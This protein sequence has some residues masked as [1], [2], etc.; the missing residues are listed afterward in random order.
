MMEAANAI[1]KQGASVE[2]GRRLKTLEDLRTHLR[3]AGLPKPLLSGMETALNHAATFLGVPPEQLPIDSVADVVDSPSDFKAHLRDRKYKR[4]TARSYC[5]SLRIAVNKARA[6]GWSPSRPEVPEWEPIRKAVAQRGCGK[7]VGYA[8]REGI[9]PSEFT[10]EHLETWAKKR[11][12]SAKSYSATVKMKE[13]FRRQIVRAG[14]QASLP[15]LTLA[16][17][18]NTNLAVPLSGLPVALRTELES[19]LKWKQAEFAPGRPRKCKH[20]PVTASQLGR[21]IRMLYGFVTTIRGNTGG[22]QIAITGL[23]DLVHEEPVTDFV[24]H[25][26]NDRQNSGR[27]VELTLAALYSAFRYH[28]TYKGQDYSWMPTLMNQLPQTLAS[29][30]LERK[31][32]KYVAYDVLSKIPARLQAEGARLTQNEK[33]QIALLAHDELLLRLLLTL[34]WRQ[35]NIRECRIGSESG[36]ANLYKE[37]V[38]S[39]VKM[40]MPEWSKERLAV[41]Q[42]EKFWQ[43]HFR[44]KETKT[45]HQVRCFLPRQLIGP[46]EEYLQLHRPILCKSGL[47][48]ELCS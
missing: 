23:S 47:I 14:L 15:R 5:S 7:I 44:E 22:R 21:I 2:P 40:A 41:N 18:K 9:V 16:T 24:A 12:D 36:A 37:R 30:K 26:L 27:T 42:Q 32:R 3:L 39:I 1:G 10:N 46:L 13:Q 17:K 38:M 20:R 4:H 8:I 28:P 43:I 34:V 31:S 45:S 11:M 48:Q 6:F 35:R 19:L 29:E 33:R 25:L